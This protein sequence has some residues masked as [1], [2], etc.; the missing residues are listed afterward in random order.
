MSSFHKRVEDECGQA[1]REL[2]AIADRLRELGDTA[3]AAMADVIAERMRRLSFDT[4]IE[5][6]P[7][8]RI[9]N[10]C[11]YSARGVAQIA[12]RLRVMAEDEMLEKAEEVI[13]YLKKLAYDSNIETQPIETKTRKEDDDA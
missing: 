8:D 1:A 9:A 6:Q 10:E 4:K 13:G 5:I 12:E 2:M 7:M 11:G 3:M